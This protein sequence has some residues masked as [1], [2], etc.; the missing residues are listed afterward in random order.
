MNQGVHLLNITAN[1]IGK[2]HH[3]H[4]SEVHQQSGVVGIQA[5]KS[6]LTNE[7]FNYDFHQGSICVL[8][9][10]ERE[11]STNLPLKTS[12]DIRLI[13]FP[14]Y[15][16]PLTPLLTYIWN[17]GCLRYSLRCQGKCHTYQIDL[18]IM[19]M[20]YKQS[21]KLMMVF[22]SCHHLTKL[23]TRL[24]LEACDSKR[25]GQQLSK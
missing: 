23:E 2:I 17:T 3:C 7:I 5:R 12:L 6:A 14:V 19:K 15:Q 10:P 1:K 20:E 9:V 4:P 22:N 25:T 16:L 8:K 21:G 13:M 18:P 11:N 24:M